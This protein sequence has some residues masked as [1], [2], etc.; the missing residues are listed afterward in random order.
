MS[1]II[2]ALV[3]HVVEATLGRD[4]AFEVLHAPVDDV[5]FV[6]SRTE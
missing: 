2:V 1:V 5:A 6:N 4:E 3:R